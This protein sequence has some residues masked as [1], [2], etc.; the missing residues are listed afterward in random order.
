MDVKGKEKVVKIIGAADV[1]LAKLEES[2]N[3]LVP[4]PS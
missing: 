1:A 4:F 3:V 2:V